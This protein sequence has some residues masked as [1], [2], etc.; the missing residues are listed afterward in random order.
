MA[1]RRLDSKQL[2]V[3]MDNS[4]CQNGGKIQQYFAREKMTRVRHLVDSPN[5]SQYDFW[6]FGHAKEQMKGQTITN[7]D[8]LE[9]L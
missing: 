9:M 4:M 5:L 3:H 8:D 2:V 7:E 1:K 6:L